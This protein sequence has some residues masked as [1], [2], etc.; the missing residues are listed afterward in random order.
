MDRL[1]TVVVELK[2]LRE[3]RADAYR[4]EVRHA[5]RCASELAILSFSRTDVPLLTD[6]QFD[7]FVE[8]FVSVPGHLEHVPDIVGAMNDLEFKR[9]LRIGADRYFMPSGFHLAKS[10]YDNPRFWM[11]QDPAY[12]Q[13]ASFHRG[14]ATEEIAAE[15]LET[16]FGNGVHRDVLIKDGKDTVTDIDLLVVAGGRALVVQAK[17]KRLTEVARKGDEEQLVKDF[18][19]AVQEAYDQGMKCR[20]ALLSTGYRLEDRD[21]RSVEIS[22]PITD[23]YV[24]CLTLEPFRAATHMLPGLLEKNYRVNLS[25]CRSVCSTWM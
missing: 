25:R 7:A 18:T 1:A 16:V 5:E 22:D 13:R 12:A 3:M 8:R 24:I 17:A 9:I 14:Q 23:V 6:R 20:R 15:M 10:V 11:Q 4:M 19:Q 2:R 21:G